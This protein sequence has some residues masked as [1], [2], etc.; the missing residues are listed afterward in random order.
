MRTNLVKPGCRDTNKVVL[1]SAANSL[2]TPNDVSDLWRNCE[3]H[4]SC[5]YSLFLVFA[6][7]VLAVV[8][9]VPHRLRLL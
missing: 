9:V 2:P 4:L 7:S 3:K 8:E 5:S 1:G 6:F